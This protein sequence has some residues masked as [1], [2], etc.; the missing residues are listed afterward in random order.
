MDFKK[1]IMNKLI[2]ITAAR[3]PA[4]CTYVVAKVVKFFMAAAKDSG[5]KTSLISKEKSDH[6]NAFNSVVIRVNGGN[7]DTFLKEWIGTIQWVGQS[8]FRKYHKRKNWFVGIYEI[9][10]NKLD[11]E[12]LGDA[13][14]KYETFRAGGPG[15]QHVNKVETAVRAVHV[16][17]GIAAVAKDSK[18]QLQNK[19]AAK[20]KLLTALETEKLE[21][22]KS[23]KKENWQQ[24]TDLERGNPVKIFKGIDFKPN[25]KSKKYRNNRKKQQKTEPT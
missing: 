25:H 3:G 12:H 14:I 21:Q 8:P 19:K 22:L 9:S 15:G 7:T 17:T 20:A 24:H 23:T 13:D 5:L 2:Q 6:K 10:T 1:I 18:S 11:F 16:P 4:E